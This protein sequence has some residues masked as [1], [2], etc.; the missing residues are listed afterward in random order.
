MV[1]FGQIWAAVVL[2]QLLLWSLWAGYFEGF[3][4]VA[5]VAVA[6]VYSAAAAAVAVETAG[7]HRVVQCL[8]VFD[9]GHLN[10]AAQLGSEGVAAAVDVVA[11]SLLLRD[12]ASL[13]DLLVFSDLFPLF[14]YDDDQ[15]HERNHPSSGDFLGQNGG[16]GHSFFV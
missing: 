16:L 4:C 2:V 7:C 14:H 15:C 6:V 13:S 12:P 8:N 11:W 3:G 1:G 10:V 5:V 9:L